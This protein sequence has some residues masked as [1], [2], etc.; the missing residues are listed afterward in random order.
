MRN[1]TKYLNI[2]TKY[3]TIF[4]IDIV[5]KSIDKLNYLLKVIN[6]NFG[7]KAIQFT[8]RFNIMVILIVSN[9]NKIFF[10]EQTIVSRLLS[11]LRYNNFA[12]KTR[13]VF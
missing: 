4:N 2:A 1:S 9:P 8:H 13:N 12:D 10:A 6:N 7:V 11:D 3:L 5:T